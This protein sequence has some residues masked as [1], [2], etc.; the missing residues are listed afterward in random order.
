MWTN[1]KR[2]YAT[3]REIG[4]IPGCVPAVDVFIERT[5]EEVRALLANDGYQQVWDDY[6]NGVIAFNEWVNHA[7]HRRTPPAIFRTY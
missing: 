7:I 3:H 2:N 4:H 1:P 6:R 5:Q